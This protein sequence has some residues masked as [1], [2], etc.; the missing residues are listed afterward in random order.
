MFEGF[1]PI[2]VV[3]AAAAL[4]GIMIAEGLYLLYAGRSDKRTA[5][6]RRMKL[7][8]NKIS[9]EQVLIQLRKERG[10][11]G[12]SSVFSLDRFRVLRT[13]SGMTT[14]LPKF[15]MIT[16]GIAFALALL[17]IWKGLPLLFGLIL[18]LILLPVLPVMAM[19]FMRKRR[20]KRFG[21]QLPEALELITRG[22]KAGHPVPVAIAM[23]AR[24]MAD[25]I[26]TE[27]G[28]VADEVTYGSDLVSALNNLFDRVGHEDL[29]LF[30]TA[31][32]IQSSSGGNLREILDG[33]S[34]T[35]RERGKLRRKVRAISTEGRMSAYILT[36][37]P[38]LLFTAIMVLMPQFYQDVWGEPKTWYM[39]SGAIFWLLLGN[40]I[41]F[42]MSNFRF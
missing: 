32:S 12:R 27:F 39:L 30:V 33:L 6:N 5:I 20:H 25:P 40:A 1:S 23:V 19:R 35:I 34:A 14:P 31:V 37:V 21:I 13:Q 2:Y 8:E 29:P 41:M 22:L 7:A 28:V 4:T 16:S 9:Q 10:I 17:T 42:K 11:D 18:F 38:A 24:E 36:A 15:L 26:G 3:Y